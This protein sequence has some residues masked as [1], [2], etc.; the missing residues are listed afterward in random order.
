MPGQDTQT[1]QQEFRKELGL[2]NLVMCQ[3]LNIVGLFWVETGAR[4]GP[5]HVAFWLLG[6]VLFYLP[7]FWRWWK[8]LSPDARRSST[9]RPFTVFM[10]RTARYLANLFSCLAASLSPAAA[11]R[12]YHF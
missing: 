4:L 8:R 5:S 2:R 12:V 10:S 9:E 3:I 11:A 7:S 6:I 1:R